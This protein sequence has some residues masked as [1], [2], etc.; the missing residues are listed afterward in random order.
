[1]VADQLVVIRAVRYGIAVK[2]HM[3]PANA[4]FIAE[5]CLISSHVTQAWLDQGNRIAAFWTAVSE[6]VD[7]LLEG[8]ASARVMSGF[9]PQA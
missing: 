6:G 2:E 9:P 3:S 7:R 4:L 5:P 8:P 1:M